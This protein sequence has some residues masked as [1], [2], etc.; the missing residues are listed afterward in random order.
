MVGRIMLVLVLATHE[1]QVRTH[2]DIER[3]ERGEIEGRLRKY[4]HHQ[5]HRV[6][7]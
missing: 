2:E 7:L 5:P 6:R 4:T 3:L 1:Q